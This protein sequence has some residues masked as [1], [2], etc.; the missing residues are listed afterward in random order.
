MQPYEN[1]NEIMDGIPYMYAPPW[2]LSANIDSVA[3][4]KSMRLFPYFQE[5]E[6]GIL[7]LLFS[8]LQRQLLHPA[9]PKLWEKELLPLSLDT[10]RLLRSIPN[11]HPNEEVYFWRAVTTLGYLQLLI[12]ETG[13]APRTIPIFQAPTLQQCHGKHFEMTLLL[14][15]ENLPFLLGVHS[16]YSTLFSSIVPLGIVTQSP[17]FIWKPI[18]LDFSHGER[19]WYLHFLSHCQLPESLLDMNGAHASTWAAYFPTSPTSKKKSLLTQWRSLQ[20]FTRRLYEHGFLTP[21]QIEDST[22]LPFFDKEMQ[23]YWQRPISTF[24]EQGSRHF[25]HRV[26]FLETQRLLHTPSLFFH[27]GKGVPVSHLKMLTENVLTQIRTKATK[28]TLSHFILLEVGVILPSVLLF[29]EWI[30]LVLL[31]VLDVLTKEVCCFRVPGQ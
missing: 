3:T 6:R 25:C 16:G 26:A 14:P 30:L 1:E 15:R 11:R 20:S 8:D 2:L 18:W 31:F 12:Q 23:I 22:Y 7:L 10:K 29:L 27:L 19:K 13:A 17:Y 24:E 21:V 4:A 28:N 9:D 5:Q